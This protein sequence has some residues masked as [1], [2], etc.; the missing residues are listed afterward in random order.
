MAYDQKSVE[1]TDL[2]LLKTQLDLVF[3]QI[4]GC[5]LLLGCTINLVKF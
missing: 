3:F 2:H 1:I 5:K 4:A